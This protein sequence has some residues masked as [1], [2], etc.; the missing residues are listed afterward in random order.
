MTFSVFVAVMVVAVLKGALV[1][2]PRGDALAHLGRLRSPAWAAVLPGSIV[3]G[4]VGVLVLPPMALGLVLLAGA[5]TPLLTAVAM[6]GVV[7]GPRAALLLAALVLVVVAGLAS[8]WIGELSASVLTALGCLTLGVALV[9]LVPGRWVLAGV[10]CMCA[11]DVALLALGVGQSAEALMVDAASH[12][13]GPAFDRAGIGP[14][15]TDYPDLV[16]AAVL[17]GFVAGHG[18]QRRA[19]MLVMALA[20]GYGMLLPHVETLPGTVPIA[21]IF[22]LLR[23]GPLTPRWRADAAAPAAAAP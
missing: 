6:V 8:G 13:H 4:T 19:A 15:S 14:I 3:V 18:V 5:A 22:I 1:A 16:L 10:V 12:V 20:A 17:G 7:R 2:L 23:W 21:V 11:I 9:R